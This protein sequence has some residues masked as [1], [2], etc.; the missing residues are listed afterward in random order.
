MVNLRLTKN[1]H[2]ASH[3]INNG[4]NNIQTN[5]NEEKVMDTQEKIALTATILEADAPIKAKR[6]KKDR[7]LLE[8]TESSTIV[9]TEDNKELLRD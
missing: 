9:L 1:I 2:R 7:G 6:I 4:K 5:I 8:R 3:F